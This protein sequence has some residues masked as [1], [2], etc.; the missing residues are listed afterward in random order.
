MGPRIIIAN[1][2]HKRFGEAPHRFQ[3]TLPYLMVD[4]DTLPALASQHKGFGHNQRRMFSLWDEDYLNPGAVPLAT[5]CRDILASLGAPTPHKIQLVTLPR[6][7]VKTFNP[8][9]FYY[10]LDDQNTVYGVLAEVTNTYK[11]KHVYYISGNSKHT[12]LDSVSD[13]V[14]YVSP[15]LEMANTYHFRIRKSV[16]HIEIYIRTMAPSTANASDQTKTLFYAHLIQQ[17]SHPMRTDTLIRSTLRY[18][19]GVIGTMA[20]ILFQAAILHFWK[21]QP[22]AP[23]RIPT[24]P[25]TL[26][27]RPPSWRERLCQKLV[28]SVFSRFD[29]C[30]L[31]LQ[32]PDGATQRFGTHGDLVGTLRVL[33]H[34]FFEQLVQ[35][36]EL[37]LGESY[38]D[39][40]WESPDVTAVLG[41]FI[42][43]REAIKSRIR[44]KKWSKWMGYLKHIL[45]RNSLKTSKKN[46]QAH[47][48]LSNAMYQCFL[49][50]HMMYS[51]AVFETPTQSLE[52]AQMTKLIRL[53]DMLRLTPEHHVLEIGS[54]WGT[55]A[56][57]MAQR[58]GCKVTTLTLSEAQYTW[59]Q[60]R[61]AALG[62]SDKVE[63]RLEDYRTHQGLYDRILSIEMIE[64]VGHEYLHTY[65]AAIERLLAP[66]GLVAI[67]AIT[68]PDQRYEDYRKRIDWIQAYIFPGGHLPSL[69]HIQ[70][71]LR[72]HT[73]LS[74]ERLDNI[75][76]HYARTLQEWRQR[77]LLN[78]DRVKALGFDE[79]F[80][81]KWVYYFS[82]CEAGF[83][84]RYIHT[85]QMVL[86]R[87]LNLGLISAEVLPSPNPSPRRGFND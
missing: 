60:S 34:A 15:F 42:R 81:R 64:A 65:F 27:I 48:D 2:S 53:F 37:G 57:E 69:T 86:T 71:C 80:I 73:E 25:H 51:S 50:T 79:A 58:Y 63:I 22:A 47:Y 83:Y 82:Y 45:Q 67:Q 85:L 72:D 26:R 87:P 10:C 23:R 55:A 70:T 54:G 78:Q 62:L 49:D 28:L 77:F 17:E 40:L 74:I 30:T 35:R 38:V 8:V 46:I 7:G 1:T 56:I 66:N 21:K 84:N 16:D 6:V 14:F 13:K 76:P 43:N 3:Y 29:T 75:A 52:D 4:V 61:I 68:I 39:G 59:V 44:G 9:S 19:M 11:D 32:L 36:G 5:K 18:P 31:I 24:H 12:F 41:V 33:D 20:R